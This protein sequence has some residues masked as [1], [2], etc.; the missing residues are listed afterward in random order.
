MSPVL[1]A[2]AAESIPAAVEEAAAAVRA[3]ELVVLPTDT[4][5]GIG[6]DAFDP[7]AVTRL[8][9]AKGRGREMPPPVLIGDAR[10]VDGLASEVPAFARDLIEQFWPGPLT[11][12]CFAQPSLHWDLGD[13]DG[14]VALR[15]PNDPVALALLREVGPMAVTS[16]NQSGAAPAT[17]ILEA[18]T[19]LG[20][21]VSVYLDGGRRAEQVPSTIVD[22][23]REE[24]MVLR[25]GSITA[26]QIASVMA[27]EAVTDAAD[28]EAGPASDR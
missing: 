9:A 20:A 25:A 2:T 16:A 11:L 27:I 22:C 13:T 7:L 10:T 3:G 18:A 14:T 5:Y 19:A 12:I 21:A 6:C 28:A 1:D 4:V 23:T 17:T 8:L 15:M 26:E 24:P